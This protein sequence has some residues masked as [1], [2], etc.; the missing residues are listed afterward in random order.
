M[1]VSV[2]YNLLKTLDV[3]YNV[4]ITEVKHSRLLAPANFCE[5]VWNNDNEVVW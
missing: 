3:V 4:Q 1:K 2:L 5:S